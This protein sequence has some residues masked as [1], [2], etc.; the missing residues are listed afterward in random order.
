MSEGRK[1]LGLFVNRKA[2][3]GAAPAAADV[4]SAVASSACRRSNDAGRSA[5][6]GKAGVGLARAPV[7]V[8]H[9]Y[10]RRR[11]CRPARP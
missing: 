9:R 11:L 4:A 7:A 2:S 6:I 8:S 5:G 3:A 10:H 1:G